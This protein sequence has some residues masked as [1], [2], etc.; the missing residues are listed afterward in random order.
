MR[1]LGVD[2]EDGRAIELSE[3]TSEGNEM[4]CAR[5][6]PNNN[7][8]PP[9]NSTLKV[10]VDIGYRHERKTKDYEVEKYQLL[11]GK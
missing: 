7:F 1:D 5:S 3:G 8:N 2:K 11:S 10:I 6:L 9:P 4:E